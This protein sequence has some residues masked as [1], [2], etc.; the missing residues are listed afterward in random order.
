M[1]TS[2]LY[3]GKW[4]HELLIGLLLL[5]YLPL[6]GCDTRIRPHSPEGAAFYSRSSPV[7]PVDQIGQFEW[8]YSH[9]VEDAE[10]FFGWLVLTYDPSAEM[11]NRVLDGTF[12]LRIEV[13]AYALTD[14]ASPRPLLED[15]PV[16]VL[17]QPAGL[18]VRGSDVTLTGFL[19]SKDRI[20][21]VVRVT[22]PDAEWAKF[23]PR[24]KLGPIYIK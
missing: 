15:Q 19:V 8:I 2:S 9:G 7:I 18:T 4:V 13:E 17:D 20:R 11:L 23:N 14:G 1:T 22:T 10:E 3:T 24:L 12:D 5:S 6:L 21:V 16:R